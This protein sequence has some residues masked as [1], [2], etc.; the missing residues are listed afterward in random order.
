MG[1]RH[2]E[3]INDIQPD[4]PYKLEE[5]KTAI[6]NFIL[7]EL[8]RKLLY[9]EAVIYRERS[10]VYDEFKKKWR[11]ELEESPLDYISLNVSIDHSDANRLL[12]NPKARLSRHLTDEEQ[13]NLFET[14]GE[15]DV[16]GFIQLFNVYSGTEKVDYRGSLRDEEIRDIYFWKD[17]D[18]PMCS[19]TI[20]DANNY[21]VS[22]LLQSDFSENMLFVYNN[23]MSLVTSLGK[24]IEIDTSSYFAKDDERFLRRMKESE[25]END[26]LIPLL[27]HMRSSTW[28]DF[29][30]LATRLAKPSDFITIKNINLYRNRI[31]NYGI[32]ESFVGDLVDASIKRRSVVSFYVSKDVW[33]F[34]P[35]VLK[36]K[37]WYAI[38]DL[39]LSS[40]NKDIKYKKG[41]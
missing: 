16:V 4:Y 12:F 36:E 15:S 9:D 20:E 25:S 13:L 19:V 28:N 1:L 27:A 10:R 21:N 2:Y 34:L 7:S 17:V 30:K 24:S 39:Y 6:S 22:C 5:V 31:L 26:A 14:Y 35:L 40:I 38:A 8:E 3:G 23:L 32:V 18:L 37:D 41:V 29:L 33:R 11:S